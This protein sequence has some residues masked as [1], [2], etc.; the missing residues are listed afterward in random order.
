MLLQRDL[1]KYLHYDPE[2]GLFTRLASGGRGVMV[3]DVA[4]TV[5]S[6]AYLRIV[7]NGKCYQAHRLAFLYMKGRF[8]DQCDHIN[9]K[10]ADNRWVNLREV[11]QAENLRNKSIQKNNTSGFTGVYW[12]K[13]TNNWR[14]QLYLNKNRKEL[15][16][17]TKLSDAVKARIDA[18]IEYG[19]HENHGM[20][21]A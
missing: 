5:N 10:R 7:V 21:A 8:P 3:G 6:D 11:T 1:K 17:F 19:F 9:H 14:V 13:H 15:G 12:H 2:T 4:G 16:Y 20:E 18:E